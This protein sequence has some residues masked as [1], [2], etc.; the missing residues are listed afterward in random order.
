M[1]SASRSTPSSSRW[2]FRALPVVAATLLALASTAFGQIPAGRTTAGQ[3]H[4]VATVSTLTTETGPARG[5]TAGATTFTVHVTPAPQP[6]ESRGTVDFVDTD[7]DGQLH[8]L[9][10]ALVADDGTATLAVSGMTDGAHSVRAVYSGTESSAA[11]TSA[12]AAVT[13]EATAAPD[14]SIS[15]TPTTLNLDAGVQG[16]VAISIAPLNRFDNY[17]SLSCAGL[18]LYATCTFL[19]SNTNVNGSLTTCP[20]NGGTQSCIAQ[21]TMTLNTVAPSGTNSLLRRDTGFVYAFLLPG[22][23]GLVGLGFGR[24]RGLRMLAMLCVVV[25]LVAGASSCAQRY[26]YFNYGPGENPGTPNGQ[27]IIRIYGTSVNGALSNL[28]CFQITL[29]VT[30]TNTAGST[31]NIITPCS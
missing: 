4:A 7:S 20:Q 26:R 27:S 25:S 29:N 18:P 2:S 6:S 10:S 24:N 21:S 3:S 22:A 12:P 23:L 14:F 15:A 19:P 28:K 31:G 11:S 9:G 30:S 5:N 13:A 17:V 8:S 16:T 1:Q